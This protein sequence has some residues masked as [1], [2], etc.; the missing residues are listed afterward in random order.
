MNQKPL[1]K[2]YD[3]EE[4]KGD[5]VNTLNY[6]RV[7]SNLIRYWYVVILILMI[8]LSIAYIVN[9]YSPVIYNIDASIIIKESGEASTNASILYNNPLVNAYRNYLNELYILKSFPLTERVILDLGFEVTISRVGNVK[10]T[11]KYR[12]A[13]FKLKALNKEHFSASYGL[14]IKDNL[15]FEIEF[16][17]GEFARYNFGDTII[18]NSKSFI[19][20]PKSGDFLDFIDK[21]YQISFFDPKSLAI[22]YS[23]KLD[24]EWA[25]EGASVINLSISGLNPLKEMDFIS[26]LI[27]VYIKQDLEKKN[28]TATRS[29]EFIDQQLSNIS[30]SLILFEN[31]LQSFKDK[32][33]IT[34]LSGQTQKLFERIEELE[35]SKTE[36]I[37]Q[38]NYLD[39]LVKYVGENGNI[40]QPILPST[41]GISDP[42][43]SSLVTMMVNLQLDSRTIN[44]ELR[45]TNPLVGEKQRQINEL[46]ENISENV[47]NI[48]ET[49]LITIEN[50]NENIKKLENDLKQLPQTERNLITIQRHY[51]LSENLYIY[52]NEKRAETGI[53]KAA[54]I[55][56][57]HLLSP[58]VTLRQN[59]VKI[60]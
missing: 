43:L 21:E 2:S 33:I 17:E 38:E 28:Q 19:V 16:S 34:N 11:E 26:K 9:R 30:D 24:V 54:T 56:D 58:E 6:K 15:G 47:K 37:V 60:T 57:I 3:F 20:I 1:Y 39:Y 8:S 25:E 5:K 44:K 14:V 40:D 48:R 36:I 12:D 7:V 52:L 23:N 50:I 31:R 42:L 18:Y 55:S 59:Q 41:V 10:N 45:L 49:N 29:L 22:A 35:E 32:N 51:S 4:L 27:E 46:K 13:P 53:S